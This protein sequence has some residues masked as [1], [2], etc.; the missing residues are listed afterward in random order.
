MDSR[1][2]FT[3][4]PIS[5]KQQVELLISR[6]MSISN[7]EEAEKFLLQ[8][9]YYRFCGYALHFEIF[10]DR[11]RTHK[12]Q[13][14][15]KFEDVKILCEFDSEL[16]KILLSAIEHIELAFRTAIC[17]KISLKYNDSHW[18]VKSKYF[19][20]SNGFNHKRLLDTCGNEFNRSKEIFINSY[21]KKYKEPELPPVWM[22]AEILSLGKWSIIYSTLNSKE[23]QK[24]IANIFNI[25]SHHLR[26]WIYGIS[27]LRNLCAHH[28]RIW[29][30]SYSIGVF[31]TKRQLRAVDNKNKVASLCIVLSDLLSSIEK[32]EYLKEKLSDLFEKYPN[33]PISKMGFPRNWKESFIWK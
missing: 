26:S 11:K 10:K 14:G 5:A 18:Y 29:N 8:V 25:K 2:Q 19:K 16:R 31:L 1:I 4:P 33:I 6:N 32:K 9:N 20:L 15:T 3:K 23:D 22:L 12:Y 7:I 30:K 28:S 17:H 27:Y 24:E 13:E 21:K